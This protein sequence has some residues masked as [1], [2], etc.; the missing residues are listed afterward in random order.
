MIKKTVNELAKKKVEAEKSTLNEIKKKLS[1]HQ[2]S[3]ILHQTKELSNRQAQQDNPNVLPKV[4]LED[5]PK[6]ISEP[7]HETTSLA[8]SGIA[9]T[10]YG[11][12]TNGLTYQQVII[13]LPELSN[14]LLNILPLYTN[15]LPEFGIG[16]KDYEAVQTWQSKISGGVSCFS[17]IRV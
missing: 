16:N 13:E 3:E 9:H 15:C 4:T 5:V 11:Q 7:T 17:S 8:G 12:P 1:D 14:E 10:F 6:H 2:V